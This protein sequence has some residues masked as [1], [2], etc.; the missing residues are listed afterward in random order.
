MNIDSLNKDDREYFINALQYTDEQMKVIDNVSRFGW[1]G[2]TI[3]MNDG[4][5]KRFSTV[6]GINE[7]IND[8]ELRAGLLYYTVVDDNNRVFIEKK[9]VEIPKEAFYEQ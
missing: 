3:N 6:E 9:A 1:L 4:E 7:Q 2:R 5:I 8:F